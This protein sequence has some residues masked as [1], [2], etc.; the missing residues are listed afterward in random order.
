MWQVELKKALRLG[1]IQEAIYLQARILTSLVNKQN[2][3]KFS[4]VVSL[5]L[6]NHIL[7]DI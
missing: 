4:V 2:I 5:W 1:V 6:L 3:S 7:L